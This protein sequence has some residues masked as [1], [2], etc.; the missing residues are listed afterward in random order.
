M[1]VYTLERIESIQDFQFLTDSSGFVLDQAGHLHQFRGNT[2]NVVDTPASF[3]VSHFH[4][5]DEAHG[6]I[7][8][9]SR[10]LSIQQGSLGSVGLGLLLLVGL[11][12][13][14]AQ[15]TKLQRW[16]IGTCCLVGVLLLSCCSAWQ[17]YRIP[18]AS[19]PYSTTLT[20]GLLKAGSY[21]LYTANKGLHS[22]VA[23][24][25]SHGQ[26]WDTHPLPTNFYATALTAIGRNYLVGTYANP[27]EGPRALHADGDIWIYGNDSIYSKVLHKNTLPHHYSI[28]VK[29]GIRGFSFS[30]DSSQL[31]VFGSDR[32]PAIPKDEV[33]ST[34]GN[35]LVLPAS[36]EPNYTLIDVPDTLEV[37]S[38]A[39]SATNELWATLDN[40][41]TRNANGKLV[42]YP[43]PSKKLLRFRGGQWQEAPLPS[44]YSFEQVLFVPGTPNG[45]V[46]ATTGGLFE[47][48]DNGATWHSLALQG[49]RKMHTWRQNLV[50]LQGQNRLVLLN[51]DTTK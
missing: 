8:G 5:L 17:Q 27:Y 37:C 1:K 16:L 21:H 2:T 47:T 6:A 38:L 49:V 44:G 32:M 42:Y 51:S 43:L 20:R 46:L 41:K 39:Q 12:K 28:E 7:V 13:L 36:L 10:L 23:F 4:F 3:S 33:N 40:K 15:P 50:L 45:Y 35:I 9:H 14:I 11:Y 34:E 18:D 26:R 25:D 24:T 48:K 29:R 30:S 19:S 22:Y 31:L